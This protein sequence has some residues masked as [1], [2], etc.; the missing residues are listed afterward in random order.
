ML[1]GLWAIW[2]KK[3]TQT[4]RRE[5]EQESGLGT[6]SAHSP[7]VLPADMDLYGLKSCAHAQAYFLL[8]GTF[9]SAALALCS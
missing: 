8:T 2:T 6:V 4:R 1:R 3:G 7:G 9:L 5:G